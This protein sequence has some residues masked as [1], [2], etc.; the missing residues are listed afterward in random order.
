VSIINKRVL[1][2]MEGDKEEKY[3]FSVNAVAV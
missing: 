2:E 3:S 1:F